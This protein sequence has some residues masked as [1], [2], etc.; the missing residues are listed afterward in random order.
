MYI[1][2]SL[3]C[4]TLTFMEHVY[5][6][7]SILLPTMSSK[8]EKSSAKNGQFRAPDSEAKRTAGN[9]LWSASHTWVSFQ[10]VQSHSPRSYPAVAP[11]KG[12]HLHSWHPPGPQVA[13]ALRHADCSWAPLQD[14]LGTTAQRKPFLQETLRHLFGCRHG[15]VCSAQQWKRKRDQKGRK[16]CQQKPRF[17][18]ETWR[19]RRVL[20]SPQDQQ[21]Q[22]GRG[23]SWKELALEKPRGAN[24]A[25]STQGRKKGHRRTRQPSVRYPRCAFAP[26]TCSAQRD[27]LYFQTF[28]LQSL[29]N[30]ENPA[31]GPVLG[32]EDRLWTR[33]SHCSHGT[34]SGGEDGQ[35][36]PQKHVSVTLQYQEEK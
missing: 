23:D 14:L 5:S 20:A 1:N 3:L 34:I 16:K 4:D 28:S 29:P 22:C 15:A 7:R 25:Y 10:G 32:V 13:P 18:G 31:T 9:A 8:H 33:Q 21:R 19:S 24:T 17:P 12:E 11:P 35:A 36:D 2:N 26:Q 27:A 30:A 6:P